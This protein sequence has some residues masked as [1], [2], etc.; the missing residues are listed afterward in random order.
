MVWNFAEGMITAIQGFFAPQTVVAMAQRQNTID[1]IETQFYLEANRQEFQ[2]ELEGYRIASQFNLQ[3]RQQTFQASLEGLKI[4]AQFAMQ[5]RGQE[6]QADLEGVRQKFNRELEDYRQFCEN[7]RLQKRQDFE[8][9]QLARRLQHEQRLEEYRRE[10]QLTLSRVQL[11]TAIE[12]ADDQAIRDTF[13]LKTPAIVI[14]DAYKIY[15]ENYRNIPLLVIISP[16]VLEFEKFPN[17]SQGFSKIEVSLTDQ[18]QEFCKYYPLTSQERPVRYQGA[19]WE[20]KSSHGKSAVDI[21]HHVL[22]SIP[23]VVLESKVDGDLLRIYLA[24]WD[25]LEKVP[26]YE[27]VLTV[28]WKEVLYPIARKYAQEWREYRMK[29]LEKGRSLEDLKRRGGDDELNLLILEEEEEDREFGRSGQHDYKYNVRE[30]KYIRELAQFLGICHC[31]LVGLMADRYHFSHADVHP[32]LP[33]LLPGLLEKVPSESLNQMLVGE[34]VSSYQ[35]LYQLAGCDRPHLIPDLYLDLALSLSHLPDQSWAKKQIKYS[36]KVWLMLRNLVSSIEEQKPGLLELLEA[37]TSALTV[38]DKEY[39]EK[40]N[41]C[42]AAIGESQH[43]EMIRVAMQ[44]QEAEYKRQQEAKRQRQL[45]VKRQRQL[46]AERQRQ[47]EA[48]RQ[49]QLEAERQEQLEA[50]R[51]EQLEAERQEQL[52]A[53]RQRQREIERKRKLENASVACTLGHSGSVNSVAISPDGQI[54]VSGSDDKTIT[55]WD[56]ST[57]QEL[58]TLTGH[59]ESVNS[60]AI[61]PDGQILVSSS[62]TVVSVRTVVNYNSESH[63][64]VMGNVYNTINKIKIWQLS[65]G[66]EL[67]TLEGD[68]SVLSL[69]I[70]PDGQILVSGSADNTIKIWQLSTGEELRTLTGHSESVNSVAISPDGQILVSGSDDKTIEI[71]QL[72][73]G[74]KLRTL[75]GAGSIN[76][77]AISPDGQILASSHTVMGSMGC[78]FDTTIKIWQLSTGEELRTLTVVDWWVNSLAISPDGQT[79]VI[80]GDYTITIW[81]LST[82]QELGT[83]TGHSE[84][85]DEVKSLAIS[86]DGQTL[87]SGGDD[88]TIMIWR[89]V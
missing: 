62:H 21:L 20:T 34:I 49:E 17:A 28:P 76:S 38:G 67:R 58:R 10:T 64:A 8:A 56:L 70:S 86:P 35:N 22:K 18:V 75:T 4:D 57:G 82:G 25:M 77:L 78:L 43:Q 88:G 6:F 73:T 2:A 39:L 74:Q 45:E 30:D 15:Q 48:E 9:E 31:I 79:L 29:L 69:A 46:E 27:K 3:E 44:R 85:S 55:I 37:V 24:G 61:S 32:K 42:L 12:L 26:H 41:G 60:V 7:A 59:S 50:E 13:P 72:S 14:L 89:V 81:D 36:I 23:T 40:L 52:E 51:Q 83:L 63:T 53:E 84:H 65:T 47:L 16:P 19:D 80:G 68:A 54:L 11:L 1:Q 87:V 5:T 66:Q 33:E 71:W